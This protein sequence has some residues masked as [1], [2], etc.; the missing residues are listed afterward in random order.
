VRRLLSLL[1]VVPVL[2][3]A[4]GDD[5]DSGTSS[6]RSTK[7][8]GG[9]ALSTT[10]TKGIAT[11]YD[12]DG[13]GNCSFDKSPGDLD[14][15]AMALPEYNDSAACGA[16]LEV[17]GPKG[18]VTVRVTDSCPGCEGSKVN[19]DLSAQAFAKIADPEQGRISV[20]YQL[21]SCATAGNVAYRFKDGSSKYWTAIQIR[22]HRVPI[23]SVEYRSKSGSWVEMGREDYNY[24]IEAKG[25][26]DLPAA[27]LALRVTA[28][29]GQ[30]LEDTLKGGV[31][32]ETTVTGTKQFK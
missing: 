6:T 3:L 25:V 9:R 1:V 11:F 7:S 16:C 8:G 29:D 24:F 21:V 23:A 28:S 26:G 27:G 5:E 15:V 22:N 12:A 31:Q 10:P 4:C 14:V 18:A 32:A 13:S 30:I 2:A 20:S 19:L 17:T